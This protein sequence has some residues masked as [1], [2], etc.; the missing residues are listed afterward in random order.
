MMRREDFLFIV[1]YDGDTAIVDG[2][3]KKRY[4]KPKTTELLEAGFFKAAFSSALHSGD[5]QEIQL[6][7]DAYNSGEES[8]YSTVDDLKRLF[9]VYEVLRDLTKV[10]V[11]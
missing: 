1:G 11:L 5:K 7:V 10:K 6:V 3:A 4:G 2:K 8:A 9:G